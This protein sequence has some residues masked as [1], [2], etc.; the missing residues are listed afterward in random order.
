V[1]RSHADIF[2]ENCLKNGILAVSLPPEQMDDLVARVQAAEGREPFTAD[3]EAEEIVGPGG[4]VRAFEIAPHE[5]TAL[6]EGLDDIGLTLKHADDISAWEQQA[7][8]RRPFL[9][10]LSIRG[11]G[12]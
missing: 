1:A 8:S 9:Q 12:L 3:L 6:L 10:T 11:R 4:Y 7:R 5:R 2:R